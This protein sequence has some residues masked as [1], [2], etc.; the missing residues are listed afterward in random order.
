MFSISSADLIC[1]RLNNFIFFSS[2]AIVSFYNSFYSELSP[3]PITSLSHGGENAGRTAAQ[4]LLRQ[5][6]GEYCQSVQL[7]WVLVER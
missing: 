5:M 4:T 3:V 6:A 7:P 1:N 2:I